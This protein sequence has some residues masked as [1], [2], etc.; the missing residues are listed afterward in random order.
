M[1]TRA[2]VNIEAVRALFEEMLNTIK[3][4]YLGPYTDVSTLVV[5]PAMLDRWMR[6][7][8]D[9]RRR[10]AELLP[11]PPTPVMLPVLT[12]VSPEIEGRRGA[13]G[14][15]GTGRVEPLCYFCGRMRSEHTTSPEGKNTCPPK[16]LI[17]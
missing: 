2:E 16:E 1:E 13:T 11:P 7:E 3:D 15:I 8:D 9:Y 4:D 6:D 12:V 5:H 17:R 10:F 14:R